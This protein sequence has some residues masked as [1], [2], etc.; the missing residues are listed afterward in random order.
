MF[1]QILIEQM[2]NKQNQMENCRIHN[3][4]LLHVN[5]RSEGPL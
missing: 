1:I 4:R 2:I 5:A 3:N